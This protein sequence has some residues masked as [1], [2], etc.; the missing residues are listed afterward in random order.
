MS[1]EPLELTSNNTHRRLQVQLQSFTGRVYTRLE[2]L[3]Y[4]STPSSSLSL[5]SRSC[6]TGGPIDF[7]K[8][9]PTFQCKCYIAGISGEKSDTCCDE[10]MLLFGGNNKGEKFKIQMNY[11]CLKCNLNFNEVEN[12]AK[13]KQVTFT[14]SL[15]C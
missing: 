2:V 15:S 14:F 1:K 5:S 11:Y 3:F 8:S 13:K 4:S 9:T 7:L 12:C 6:T 10:C